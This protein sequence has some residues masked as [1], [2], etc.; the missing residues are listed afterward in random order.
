M[1]YESYNNLNCLD[2]FAF[3]AGTECEFTFNCYESNEFSPFDI[4]DAMWVLAPYGDFETVEIKK[5]GCS[6]TAT[7][8]FKVILDS[9]DTEDLSGKYIQQPIVFDSDGK[10]YRLAQGTITISPKIA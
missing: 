3:V 6:I 10:S 4:Q 8:V 1:T 7:G 9:A 2:E 5:T